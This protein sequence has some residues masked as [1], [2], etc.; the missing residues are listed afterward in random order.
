MP[1]TRVRR[2]CRGTSQVVIEA[3]A[4]EMV[5]RDRLVSSAAELH[6]IYNVSLHSFCVKL[7]KN[8]NPTIPPTRLPWK[9]SVLVNNRLLQREWHNSLI[10]SCPQRSSFSASGCRCIW[11]IHTFRQCKYGFVDL[12]PFWNTN[13]HLQHPRNQRYYSALICNSLSKFSSTG[14]RPFNRNTCEDWIFPFVTEQTQLFGR[15]VYH[16]LN[17]LQHNF[18]IVL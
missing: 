3:A 9:S 7:R 6:E 17:V 18:L 10:V 16:L 4:A 15:A 11:P 14:I 8:E 13:D 12:N 2:T 1:R 5:N